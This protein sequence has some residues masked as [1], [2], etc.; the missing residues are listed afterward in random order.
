MKIARKKHHVLHDNAGAMYGSGRHA[1]KEGLQW[2]K[3]ADE[4]EISHEV[5]CKMHP[6]SSE[7]RPVEIALTRLV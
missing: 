5:V 1:S 7:L 4:E 6:M 3:P 2:T